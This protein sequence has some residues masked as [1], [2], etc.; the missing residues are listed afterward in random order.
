VIVRFTPPARAQLIAAATYIHAD[1]P[2]AARDFRVR[3]GDALRRFVDF[4]MAGRVIPE[5][6][7]LGFREILVDSYRIFYRVKD[8]NLWV[9][10]V[11]HDAQIAEEP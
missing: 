10:G 3:V 5:F 6:P 2:R 11:W 8:D 4:P 1:R 7:Q 9:V